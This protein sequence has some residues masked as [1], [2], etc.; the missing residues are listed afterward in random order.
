MFDH[1]DT[2]FSVIE[3]AQRI[4]LGSIERALHI[5]R[6]ITERFGNILVDY[7]KQNTLDEQNSHL[8]LTK[9]LLYL[10]ISTIRATDAVLKGDAQAPNQ[11]KPTQKKQME[12]AS[13]YGDY[14]EQRFKVLA[15]ILAFMEMP[16]ER[17][18]AMVIA[19]E[20]FVK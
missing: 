9:M 20:D 13:A 1:F 3:H 19:E 5:L 12:R 11:K 6:N 10:L 14:N 2:F 17:L 7:L 8:N 18:W 15:S 16:V 4:P